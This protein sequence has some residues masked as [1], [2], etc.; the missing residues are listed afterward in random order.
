MRGRHSWALIALTILAGACGWWLSRPEVQPQL[1]SDAVAK[2]PAIQAET[3]AGTTTQGTEVVEVK[4]QLPEALQQSFALVAQSYAAEVATPAY[5]RPLSSADTQLL[6]PNQFFAQTIPLTGGGSIRLEASQY[7]FSYPEPVQVSLI[8][9]GI[10][11]NGVQVQLL[12]QQSGELLASQALAGQDGRYDAVLA[13]ETASEPGQ[14]WDGE[15]EVR[16]VFDARGET[17]QLQTAIEYSQPVAEI[18]GVGSP[19]PVGADLVIPLQLTVK[20]AGFYRLRANLFSDNGQPVAQ[21]TATDKLSSGA[22]QL[23]LKVHKSVLAGRNGP[24]WLRTFVLEQMSASPAEPTR[25][26]KSA[27][28]EYQVEYMSLD[29]LSDEP[30]EMSDEERQ[31]LELLQKLAEKQ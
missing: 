4:E 31:R 10:E 6:A 17:Q 5:S 20:Q 18:T 15:L 3:S 7:R 2:P 29:S 12:S 8:S 21:L 30:V 16:F 27:K 23:K 24:Y 28:P 11:L 1:K 22:Q 9:Q 13:P 26:G 25:Y 19:S 14:G